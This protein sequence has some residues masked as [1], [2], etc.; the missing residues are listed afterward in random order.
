MVFLT[1]SE[2]SK[3]EE[4]K[5]VICFLFQALPKSSEDL[6]KTNP[7]FSGLEL[8]LKIIFPLKAGGSFTDLHQPSS[9]SLE[10][11][12]LPRHRL[13][14]TSFPKGV[15]INW[16]GD[17]LTFSVPQLKHLQNICNLLLTIMDNE[18]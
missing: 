8:K 7:G 10:N 13:F 12:A 15:R 14:C 18:E 11:M 9:H 17:F 4:E 5:E 1:G 6:I 3:M 16:H 2:H